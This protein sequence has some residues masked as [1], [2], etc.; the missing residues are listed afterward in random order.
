MNRIRSRLKA[1]KMQARV[2]ENAK[3][4]MRGAWNGVADFEFAG[5]R[6]VEG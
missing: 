4:H 2:L 5:Y 6:K 1:A 3:T